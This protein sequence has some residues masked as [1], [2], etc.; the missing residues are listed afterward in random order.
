[1]KVFI[2]NE[3]IEKFITKYKKPVED[4]S[5]VMN[6]GDDLDRIKLRSLL[7]KGYVDNGLK[8]DFVQVCIYNNDGVSM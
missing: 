7:I 1:M 3:E 2:T 4:N 6:K 5:K 8:S